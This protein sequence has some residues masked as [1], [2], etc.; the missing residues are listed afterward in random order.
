[1]PEPN[2]HTQRIPATLGQPGAVRFW[3]ALTLTGISA[4]IGAIALTKL[5]EWVQRLAWGGNGTDLLA[6]AQRVDP[7]RH[8]AVLVGAGLV[9]GFG[10]IVLRQLSSA[11]GIDTTAAIWFYAGRLPGV[12]TLGSA[13]LSIFIVGM[14][15]SLGREGAPK[16][17]AAVAANWFSDLGKLSDEQRRLLVACAAGAGMSAAYGVPVGGALFALE[18]MRGLLALRYVLPALFASAIAA[19][20]SWL[21]LPDAPTYH[22]PSFPS[23]PSV[24]VWSLLAGPRPRGRNA[25]QPPQPLHA[26]AAHLQLE[27][28]S[29]RAVEGMVRVQ[30]IDPAHRRRVVRARQ[31]RRTIDARTRQTQQ[32]A[33]PP[34]R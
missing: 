29:P 4:G 18:V 24:I 1:M 15:A 25:H 10:Q 17:A 31:R 21:V 26:L 20:I 9:T 19:G 33:L 27:C 30:R 32:R 7:W 16:Q 34:H 11:N 13:V 3:T 14:G 23:S 6:S 12:R 5:L 2:Q 28:N 22:I 8:V